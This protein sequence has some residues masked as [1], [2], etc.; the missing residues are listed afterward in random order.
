MVEFAGT[1][2]KQAFLAVPADH[3][4]YDHTRSFFNED[5]YPRFFI[6]SPGRGWYRCQTTAEGRVEINVRRQSMIYLI[7]ADRDGRPV[8]V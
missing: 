1:E 2:H 7:K 6:P 5:V 3:F 4:S 8:C